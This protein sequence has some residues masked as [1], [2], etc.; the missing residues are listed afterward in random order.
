MVTDRGAARSKA[1]EYGLLIAVALVASGAII[2]YWQ[3]HQQVMQSASALASA[4]EHV[5]QLQQQVA[6]Q[7]NDLQHQS[8]VI[9]AEAKPDLP[10]SIGFRR[11]ILG[12]G[13]VMEL[14]NN[15]GSQIEVGAAFTSEA[16]GLTQQRNIVLPPNLVVQL[17]SSQGWAFVPG[18]R[19]V[20]RNV[21]YRPSEVVVPQG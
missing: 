16:T 20:F 7:A 5:S 9:Q 2:A 14:R 3:E 15:S 18:Q 19:I 8:T 4:N 10:L 1:S 21:S 13:L 12:T 6:Q 17:G 11:A